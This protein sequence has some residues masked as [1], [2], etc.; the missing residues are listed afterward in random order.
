MG[1]SA[2]NDEGK[3]VLRTSARAPHALGRWLFWPLRV[4][5]R[6]DGEEE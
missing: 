4:S 5:Q 6:L 3:E 1:E 2:P